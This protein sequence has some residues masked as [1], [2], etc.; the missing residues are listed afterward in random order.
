[1]RTKKSLNW[2]SIRICVGKFLPSS[3]STVST[4]I[5][6][7][8]ME[9]NKPSDFFMFALQ[10]KYVILSFT[11]LPRRYAVTRGRQTSG[12][13]LGPA[14][15]LV[16]GAGDWLS[17]LIKSL[18]VSAGIV[19]PH[20]LNHECWLA[21]PVWRAGAVVV[22]KWP[23]TTIIQTGP[24]SFYFTLIPAWELMVD[25]SHLTLDHTNVRQVAPGSFF[26]TRNSLQNQKPRLIWSI[27]TE[28]NN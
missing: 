7:E 15:L 28:L 27:C 18:L 1:M 19:F 16:M 21:R 8:L 6:T 3:A 9:P 20:S 24:G 10:R 11:L 26:K 13:R 12:T 22:G 5:Y 2:H 25:T 23:N 14:Q 4:L 17:R